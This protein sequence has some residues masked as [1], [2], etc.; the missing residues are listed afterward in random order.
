MAAI[1]LASEGGDLD[2]DSDPREEAPAMLWARPTALAALACL[3]LLRRLTGDMRSHS[4]ST[5]APQQ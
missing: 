2:L 4:L 5:E 1:S 3:I